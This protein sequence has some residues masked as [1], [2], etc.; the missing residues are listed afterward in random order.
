MFRSCGKLKVRYWI[1]DP[2]VLRLDAAPAAR[3]D[4]KSVMTVCEAAIKIGYGSDII[5]PPLCTASVT[6][7]ALGS[8]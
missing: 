7:G 1:P 2:A 6:I 8:S 4:R 5:S 3:V